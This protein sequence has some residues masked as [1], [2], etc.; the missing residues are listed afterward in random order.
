MISSD[1]ILVTW[2]VDVTGARGNTAR[3]TKATT[4]V[5]SSTSI[6]Q[7]FTV[8]NPTVSL[9]AGAGS[10]DQRKP[11]AVV[12]PNSACSDMCG[13]ATYRLDLVYEVDGQ[14]ISVGKSGSFICAY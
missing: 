10:A 4:T 13:G 9:V 11:V 14:I 2:T 6:V 12:S 5:S 8:D 3:L 7:D 1:P